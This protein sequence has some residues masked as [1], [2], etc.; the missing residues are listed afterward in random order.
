MAKTHKQRMY[1]ELNV[2]MDGHP[3]MMVSDVL[4]VLE[5]FGESLWRALPEP[6]KGRKV[7]ERR[8]RYR[9]A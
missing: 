1:D 5:T 2:L 6:K 7:I 3:N 8:S 9:L 4:F